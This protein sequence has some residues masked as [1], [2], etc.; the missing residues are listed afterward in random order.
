MFGFRPRRT[1]Y[2]ICTSSRSGGTYFCDLLKQTEMLGIPNEYVHAQAGQFWAPR[3]GLKS[4]VIDR[5]FVKALVRQRATPNGVFGVKVTPGVYDDFA[6]HVAPKLH[7]FFTRSDIV[8]QA[9]SLYRAETSNQFHRLTEQAQ[10]KV[11]QQG[12]DLSAPSV[13]RWASTN[14]PTQDI[15]FDPAEIKKCQA[16]IERI[17][18]LWEEKFRQANID[19]LR[20]TYEQLCEDPVRVINT[21]AEHLDVSLPEFTPQPSLRIMRDEL[22]EQWVQQMAELEGTSALK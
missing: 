1:V 14:K 17:N 19:P 4:T 2:V 7:I 5:R 3:L 12:V 20:V 9:I 11:A 8:R 18:H 6:R 10:Q 13:Q 22:T 15:P 21:V 16:T